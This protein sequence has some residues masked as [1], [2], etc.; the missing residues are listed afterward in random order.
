MNELRVQKNLSAPELSFL[1]RATG[2]ALSLGLS[3]ALHIVLV[4]SGLLIGYYFTY[5]SGGNPKIDETP[6][7]YVTFIEDTP[8]KQVIPETIETTKTKEIGA[9]PKEIKPKQK[10]DIVS[11]KIPIAEKSE[12]LEPEKKNETFEQPV[13]PAKERTSQSRASKPVKSSKAPDKRFSGGIGNDEI[14]Y[15]DQVRAIIESNRIY[16]GTARRRKLE[17]TAIIQIRVNHKGD[18]LKHRFVQSTNHHILDQAVLGMI[19]ASDPLPAIPSSINKKTV[20]I[21][22]PIGFQ[23][24]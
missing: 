3:A 19:K 7:V 15:T 9:R 12:A 8:S 13:T 11:K 2:G 17:G 18:I 24:K 10:I 22:I 23:I 1:E 16:P 4:G 6:P 21:K 5:N 20:S 14:Q